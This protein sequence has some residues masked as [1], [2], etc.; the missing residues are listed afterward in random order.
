VFGPP[1]KDH[2]TGT[3]PQH[4]FARN[5]H[6][7]YL[8]KSSTE[9]GAPEAVSSGV[10]LDFGLSSA[11]LSAEAKKAWPFQFGL[12]YSVTL[13]K[14]GLQTMLN[15][16][17]EGNESFE[18]QVLLHSYFAVDDITRI[19]VNGLGSAT[20]EDKVLN[21]ATHEQSSPGLTITGEVD[22]KYISLKQDTTSLV[23]DGKPYLDVVRDNLVDTVVWNP[24]IAKAEG[25]GDF[26]PKDGYKNMLCIE[27]GAVNGWQKLEAGE[28]FEGGQIVR[29]Q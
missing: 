7:E 5:S 22:R 29:P 21:G 1:P 12:V 10:K 23:A 3:L 17:N 20:Y 18:F 27:V 9:S 28:T 13:A 6:W 11:N 4:G 25:M 26:E 14:D 19:Q 8:G 16:R 24:W 15:V 2:V